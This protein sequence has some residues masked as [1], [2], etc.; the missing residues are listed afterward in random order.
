MNKVSLVGRVTRNVNIKSYGECGRYVNINLAVEDYDRDRKEKIT[1]FIDLIAWNY[2]ADFIAQ[3]IGKG[4]L[5]AI[6]GTIRVSSF[7]N[8]DGNKKYSTKVEVKECKIL[9]KVNRNVG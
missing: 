9:S 4:D 1:N 8:E 7:S 6:D 2:R 3:Y 5:I